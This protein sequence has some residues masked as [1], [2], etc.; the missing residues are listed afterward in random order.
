MQAKY[1]KK[2]NEKGKEREN[3][4]LDKQNVRRTYE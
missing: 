1:E 4:S 3:R 2:S